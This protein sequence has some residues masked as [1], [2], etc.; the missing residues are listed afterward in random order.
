MMQWT[1]SGEKID[2][3]DALVK[4]IKV[5]N[6][7]IG[8]LVKKS[9][10]IKPVAQNLL[11]T[12]VRFMTT[13]SRFFANYFSQNWGSDNHF[14]VLNESKPVPYLVCAV[15]NSWPFWFVPYLVH[16]VFDSWPFWFVPYLVS[17]LYDSCPF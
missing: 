12:K 5:A 13:S 17:V 15:F 2:L 11:L 1:Q 4:P 10:A 16:A 14:E 3:F 9:G 6:V 7:K 8:F